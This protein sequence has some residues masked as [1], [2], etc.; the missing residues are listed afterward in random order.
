MTAEVLKD[1]LER[2]AAWPKEVQV[3]LA[4]IAR[5]M[6]AQLSGG[7]YHASPDELEGIDRG[8]K[9]ANEGLFASNKEIEATFAKHRRA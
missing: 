8:L 5:E 1:V 4:E 6:D 2:V 7:V 3:E 9:D